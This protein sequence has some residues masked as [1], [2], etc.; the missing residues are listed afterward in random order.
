MKIFTLERYPLS[1]LITSVAQTI[2]KMLF[3]AY[4]TD[5]TYLFPLAQQ[6][7]AQALLSHTSIIIISA[8]PP[9]RQ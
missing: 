4:R 5:S 6:R 3:F 9:R 1:G 8:P 2:K 7:I